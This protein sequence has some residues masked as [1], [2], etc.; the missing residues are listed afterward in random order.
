M[1]LFD[2]LRKGNINKFEEPF[3]TDVRDGPSPFYGLLG[4]KKKLDDVTAA[5]FSDTSI[6][7]LL[8]GV[9]RLVR[10]DPTI[11][12]VANWSV[13]RPLFWVDKKLYKVTTVAADSTKEFA[14]VALGPL[15]TAGSFKII[16]TEGEAPGLYAAALTKAA[17]ALNDPLVLKFAAN[18]ADFDVELDATAF[19]NA[20]VKR[21]VG[22]VDEAAVA[23]AVKRIVLHNLAPVQNR[24]IYT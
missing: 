15:T 13:G 19:S 16:Q 12:T 22:R 3:S 14:G 9:Y 2:Y 21:M 5:K 18:L 10:S 11:V 6:F 8:N 1:D 24:G 4:M 17:P 7:T 20:I 23:G